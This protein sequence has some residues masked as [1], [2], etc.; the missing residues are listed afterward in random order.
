M[1]F[2]SKSTPKKVLNAWA[3]YDWA[4]SV[5]PLVIST[6]VFPIYY[7]TLFVDSDYIEILGFNYKNTALIQH[8]TS[9]VFLLLAFLVPLMSGIAD[10]LGNK[11]SFMKLFVYLGSFS[12]MGLYFF[13]LEN[14][15]LGLSFY[16]LALFSFW[17]SLVFYNSYLP[18]IT[19][20][21]EQDNASALGYSY[22]YVGSV[23]LLLVNLLMINFPASFGFEDSDQGSIE[24]M[25]VSFLTVGFWWILFSQYTFYYLPSLKNKVNKKELFKKSIFFSGFNKL[26]TVWKLMKNEKSIKKFLI[27]L[28]TYYTAVQT[29]ILIATYFGDQEII[30][31]EGEKL[32]GL[33]LSML[34]IQLIAIAGSAG[35]AFLSNRI[36]NIK[37]LIIFNIIWF[38]IC[39]GAYFIKYSFEF[40]I[41]AGLVGLVMGGIQSLS[42]STYSKLIPDTEDTCSYFSF[43]QMCMI[44]SIVFG[45]FMSGVIDQLTGSIRSSIIVFAGLFILGAYLLRGV[46]MKQE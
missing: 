46:K 43:Y 41:V 27:A 33:I 40:Y 3:F 4:N 37:T 15:Y 25:K 23:F 22:G 45:T 31:G 38:L 7:G 28:F 24:A 19:S 5:Y 16:L 39:I 42:R 9:L 44:I 13:D 26:I 2:S 6:A 35:G 14:I 12:C 17:A 18:D 29:I 11:K 1:F 36:G 8:V 32:F 10:F 21:S 20:P 34:I 30:W